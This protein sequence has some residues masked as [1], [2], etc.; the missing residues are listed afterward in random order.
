MTT[1]MKP[2]MVDDEESD[3]NADAP[4]E[5]ADNDDDD[6]DDA[7]KMAPTMPSPMAPTMETSIW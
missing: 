6:D 7:A 4:E 2:K 3:V 5:C 1:P